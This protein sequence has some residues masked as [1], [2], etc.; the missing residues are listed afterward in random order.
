MG[1]LFFP[2]APM[3][4]QGTSTSP[5]PTASFSS[6]GVKQVTLQVCNTG[7][8]TSIAKPVTV[9]NPAPAIVSLG[10]V[11]PLV[12]AGQAVSLSAQTTGRP[13]LTHRW[14]ISGT[15]STSGNLVL[16]GNPIQWNTANPGIGT[17]QVRLEVMNGSGSVFSSFMPVTVERMTFGD[18]PPTYWAWQ[19]VETLYARGIT[20]GCSLSPLL[21]CPGSNVSRAEMAVFLVRAGRGPTYVPPAATGIF[22]DVPMGYWAAPFIEQ[23]YAD[24]ITSGCSLAPL[25]YCPDSSLSRAEMAVFLLRAKHGAVYVPPPATGTVFADVP[26]TSFGA[27]WI[28]QLAAEGITAG[29]ATSPLRYCPDSPVSRDQMAAFLVRTFNL[30]NP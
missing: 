10:S 19:Y 28:E 6:P 15:G 26:A 20:S 17:Y 1:L 13:S 18:V 12:G 16:T 27:S 14:T 23:I 29:C 24:G 7:G 2:A 4:G 9:L 5:N 25:G 8:C 30:T 11:P 22:F 3:L 21:Y